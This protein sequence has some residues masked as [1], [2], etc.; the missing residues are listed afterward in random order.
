MRELD[1][2]TFAGVMKGGDDGPVV[3]PG[4]PQESR[5]YE[6]VQKGVM[7]KGGKPLPPGEIASIRE[8][9]EGGARSRS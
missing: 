5:L 4:K 3:T 8:W 7:P 9:I 6:M 1:L 2:S